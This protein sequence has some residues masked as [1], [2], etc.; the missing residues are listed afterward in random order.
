M[1]LM[2]RRYFDVIRRSGYRGIGKALAEPIENS[3][4]AG[5]RNIFVIMSECVN[6]LTHKR[7]INEFGILD[8]GSGM[9]LTQMAQCL[10]IGFTTKGRYGIG[11]GLPLSSTYA[12]SNVEV[13]SWTEDDG[14][15]EVDEPVRQV[16]L[17]I[18][19]VKTGE[20]EEINDPELTEIPRQYRSFLKY[21]TA[22]KTYDFT[23]HGT[24][25][26]WKN[27]DNVK[28]KTRA[29]LS[30]KLEFELGRIF[31]HFINTEG[32]TIKLITIGH[33]DRAIDVLPNDPLFAMKPNYVLGNP[34]DPA[35]IS[36]RANINCTEPIFEAYGDNNGEVI[37]PVSYTDKRTGKQK[38]S[39]VL[40]RFTKVRAEFY[41]QTAISNGDP[42]SRP[43][44]KYV[45]KLEGISV[46]R[47]GREID[48]GAFDFY[49]QTNNPYHRWWG[50]E[51]QF[52]PE[53]DEVFQVPLNKQFVE[54]KDDAEPAIRANNEL[55]L[56]LWNR[57]A[58]V[59]QPTIIK[60]IADNKV[61]RRSA[62]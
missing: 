58:Q 34:N 16:G 39:N 12:T 30:E 46:V 2:H 42:G 6:P 62:R 43:I 56:P 26:Y 29:L 11:A 17:D 51:I 38:L 4:H 35:N 60:M 53:L 49:D 15:I 31:R 20:Q 41:D 47:A 14:P 37:I 24:L 59:I 18:S 54:L 48:F 33:E 5:A 44:G 3:I 52:G 23:Q 27:C 45:K 10:N 13:Y 1:L 25:V 21:R 7:E 55:V 9:D 8:D 32:I 57:L 28:P 22:S 61:L 50:C 40:I 36:E 19:K